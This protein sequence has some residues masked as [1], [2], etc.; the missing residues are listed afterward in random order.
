MKVLITTS[1]TLNEYLNHHNNGNND[2]ENGNSL[3][4]IGPIFL[5]FL[6]HSFLAS[7]QKNPKNQ[8]QNLHIDISYL[9]MNVHN[10]GKVT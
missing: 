1:F 7:I 9:Y 3:I 2:N 10:A 5:Y 4:N 8:V 6:V